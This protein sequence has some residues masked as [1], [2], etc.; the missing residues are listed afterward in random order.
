MKILLIG[1]SIVDHIRTGEEEKTKPGGIYYSVKGMLPFTQEKDEISLVTGVQTEYLD[2]FNDVYNRINGKYIGNISGMPEVV[3]TIRE[4]SER[5]EV[6]RNISGS[7][8]VGSIRNFDDFDGILINMI[9]GFD[10]SIDDI[11]KIRK[12]FHGPVYIDIHTLSRGLNA[13]MLREFRPVPNVDEWLKNVNIVQVNETELITI[14]EGNNENER[15]NFVLNRGPVMLLVTKAEN[16]V[17]LYRNENGRMESTSLP[18]LDVEARNKIGC[19]DIFGA[20]FFY[21]YI[22]TG[23]YFDSLAAAN[24]AAGISTTYIESKDFFKLKTDA[25]KR[26]NKK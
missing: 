17:T 7:L 21:S 4:N 26:I 8:P 20:V 23:N 1:H 6:Y 3:L 14:S 24:T 19:G 2:L 13:E 5:E 11:K 15:A 9:T 22:Q 10:L 25:S 16:G 12:K 18:G